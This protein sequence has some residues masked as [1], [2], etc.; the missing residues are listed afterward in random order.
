M[1]RFTWAVFNDEGMIDGPGL[2]ESEANRLADRYRT[3]GDQHA[4]AA[5]ECSDHEGQRDNACEICNQEED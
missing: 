5:K 4:I 1:S 3:E 2:S